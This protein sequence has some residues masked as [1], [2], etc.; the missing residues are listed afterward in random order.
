MTQILTALIG[1]PVAH[2]K[3]PVIHN[4]WI[5]HYGLQGRYGAI[6]V[7][8]DDLEKTVNRLVSENYAGFNLTLPHKQ[9]IMD[10]CNT[11]D[12]SAEQI[13]AV[14]M[15]KISS[16]GVLHGFNTDAF[17][18]VENIREHIPDYDFSSGPALILGA[19]GTAYAIVHGLK[20]AGVE[21]IYITNRT[22]EKATRLA[23]RFAAKV[24][25]WGSRN[26]AAKNAALLV[27]AT[28]L[29]MTGQPPLDYNLE[30]LPADAV[31]CDIVYAPLKPDLLR[32]AEKRGN[33]TIPG[34]GMLLHQA[35]PAFQTWYGTMPDVT[36]EL[37]AM[38][39]G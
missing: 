25:D 9:A 18:F 30:Y 1:Y 14:N 23:D 7:P 34:I 2:S 29:G 6:E 35:R 28:S 8:P 19:G 11:L 38:V 22:K 13:G 3:S 16:D 17:G 4:Y 24:I 27:N 36:D 21:Q 5:K 32:D 31:V 33:R 12:R 10:L 37:R 20:E 39:D 26:A 15:V